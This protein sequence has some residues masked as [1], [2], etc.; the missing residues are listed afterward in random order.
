MGESGW[1]GGRLG[2][3]TSDESKLPDGQGRMNRFEHGVVYWSPDTGARPGTGAVLDQWS[4]TGF[5]ASLR[6]PDGRPGHAPGRNSEIPTRPN[7]Q[8]GAPAGYTLRAT[9][10]RVELVDS[11][12]AVVAGVG[13]PMGFD[14]TGAPVPVQSS[15]EGHKLRLQLGD[16]IAYPIEFP[17]IA[18]AGDALD[19]WWSTR[20]QQR[21]TCENEPYDC[22]RVR[23]ARGPA[24]DL[25]KQAFP[26]ATE[27]DGNRI[28][29]ARHCIWNG[30]TEG[31]NQGFAE[32]MATA[33]ER[34]GRANPD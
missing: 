26:E 13:L 25:S 14:A 30:L 27:T 31:A 24:F 19:A 4:R 8:V 23:N 33:H 6:I 21:M 32:R 17:A 34:D 11:A 5:E 9:P 12:G 22:Y 7:L 10:Q 28:D 15:F 29:A 1:E 16:S 3:P 2:Y 18:A 20:V